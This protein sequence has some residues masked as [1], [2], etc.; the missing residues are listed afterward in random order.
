MPDKFYRTPDGG[1]LLYAPSA[2]FSGRKVGPLMKVKPNGDLDTTFRAPDFTFYHTS[3]CD[4]GACPEGN[5]EFIPLV[6]GSVLCIPIESGFYYQ[7]N[8]TEKP[9]RL[10]ANGQIDTSFQSSPLTDGRIITSLEDGKILC[11]K[12]YSSP[13]FPNYTT[14]NKISRFFPDGSLDTSFHFSDTSSVLIQ[15]VPD[16]NG[17]VLL[18][19]K[20]FHDTLA[21]YRK[22]L[23]GQNTLTEKFGWDVYSFAS[24]PNVQNYRP[25]GLAYDGNIYELTGNNPVVRRKKPDGTL[26]T[27]FHPFHPPTANKYEMDSAGN[28]FCHRYISSDSVKIYLYSA[29]GQ[30]IDSI[31][32]RRT[33]YDFVSNGTVLTIGPDHNNR[34]T[35]EKKNASGQSLIKKS[36]RFG[37]NGKVDQVLTD[38]S[39][40]I[41]AS[42]SF[43][44]YN[45][46]KSIGLIRLLP[47]GTPDTT[48][49]CQ[50]FT[51]P[52]T[53]STVLLDR[54]S[55]G[56][57]L[58][59]SQM[60][61]G[62]VDRFLH[63]IRQDGSVDTS[64]GYTNFSGYSFQVKMVQHFLHMADGSFLATVWGESS[65]GDYRGYI[66]RLLANGERDSSFEP[67]QLDQLFQEYNNYTVLQ[68]I[69]D[70]HILVTAKIWH[71]TPGG[72]EPW[73]GV[74]V[75]QIGASTG[76]G[77][78]ILIKGYDQY[79]NGT[80]GLLSDQVL[81]GGGPLRKMSTTGIPDNTFSPRLWT[82]QPL[83]GPQTIVQVLRNEEILISSYKAYQI[84]DRAFQNFKLSK[85][86]RDGVKDT[87]F[88]EAIINGDIKQSVEPDSLHLYLAGDLVQYGSQ[89]V[90]YICRIHNQ[91]SDILLSTKKREEAT[92]PFL[93]PNPSHNEIFVSNRGSEL[94]MVFYS[95]LGKLHHKVKFKTGGVL[96]VE[97][98]P[99]GV[100]FWKSVDAKGKTH[101]GKLVKS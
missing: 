53:Y 69:D 94:D 27:S 19:F 21:Y 20:N 44:E 83:T 101:F 88:S 65:L 17:N 97:N 49:R 47:N 85:L 91:K 23:S 10:L 34:W 50:A 58:V 24:S 76:E 62:P 78:T 46:H 86:N 55:N 51:K 66:I 92:D 43:T 31:Y 74:G 6:D 7:S 3:F 52:P 30:F 25:F 57:Y 70:Q 90:N 14:H 15:W 75:L 72:Y 2:L 61:E 28:L 45:D 42:G 68:D 96:S 82:G 26:D 13:N 22:F 8:L 81:I 93:F 73:F 1:A 39:N 89:P 4:M 48:F 32:G 9:V 11:L 33:Q 99:A 16:Q 59:V 77:F 63:R 37:F 56:D 29:Q 71:D 98:R 95:S 100:Y 40:R 80:T 60:P 54:F 18:L 41:L 36:T 79:I 64:F 5:G 84:E 35:F 67:I 38:Q 12:N 87:A